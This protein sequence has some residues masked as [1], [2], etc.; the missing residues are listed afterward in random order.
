MEHVKD[1]SQD[2]RDKGRIR[3]ASAKKRA[4]SASAEVYRHYKRKTGVAAS[5]EERVHHVKRQHKSDNDNQELAP[6][7]LA[8]ELDLANDRNASEVFGKF[9]RQVWYLVRSLPEILHHSDQI[10]DLFNQYMLSLESKPHEMTPD[11]VMNSTTDSR[12][13]F[14]TNHA[15]ADILHLY[16]VLARD[17]RHEI[18]PYLHTKIVPRLVNDLLN[19]PPPESGKQ[20]IPLDVSVVEHVFRT[21]S[22]IFRYDGDALLSENTTGKDKEPCLESLRQ[23]YGSTLANRR[24]LV[25]R[26][27]AETYAPLIRKLSDRAQKRHVRRV[28]RALAGQPPHENNPVSQRLQAD[29]VDGIALL[30]FQLARGVPGKM[31]SKGQLVVKCVLDACASKLGPNSELV[32]GVT[33]TLLE[34]LCYHLDTKEAAKI[35]VSVIAKAKSVAK[36]DSGSIFERH[37]IELLEGMVNFRTGQLLKEEYTLVEQVIDLIVIV[38]DKENFRKLPTENKTAAISLLCS[39]WKAVP[40]NSAFSSRLREQLRFAIATHDETGD[41]PLVN[42]PLDIVMKDLVPALPVDIAMGSIGSVVLNAASDVSKSNPQLAIAMIYALSSTR[43]DADAM[44]TEQKD[45]DDGL[46]FLANAEYCVVSSDNKEKLLKLCMNSSDSIK[47]DS[48][49]IAAKTAC[50]VAMVP[51]NEEDNDVTGYEKQ[52]SKWL[53][54]L[55]KKLSNNGAM[56]DS[57][58]VSVGIIMDALAQFS[59]AAAESIDDKSRISDVLKKARTI[60]VENLQSHPDSLWTVK[61]SAALV[62]VLQKFDLLLTED[63]N[64]LFEMLTPNLHDKNHFHRLRTLEILSSFPKKPFVMDHADLDLT[65]DLD[66]EPSSGAPADSAESKGPMGV[67]NIIDTLIAIESTPVYFARERYITSLVS[68]VEVMGRSGKLPVLYAEAAASHM[69]GI[70]NIK[71]APIWTAAVKALVGLARGHESSVWPPAHARIA[72]LMTDFPYRDEREKMTEGT[73]VSL[74]DPLAHHMLC[75]QWETSGGNNASV[76]SRDIENANEEGRVSRHRSTDE[77]TV[78]E[79]L[80]KVFEEAPQLLVAHSRTMVPII[81]QFLHCQYFALHPED[82]DARELKLSEH[83]DDPR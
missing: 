40:N 36:D 29:A 55:L 20:P 82:P 60:A 67:C 25:R 24:Q 35:M 45:D 75:V 58:V 54:S 3:F 62:K 42:A 59:L 77:P 39:S 7:T 73:G 4:K 65:E 63:S 81:L 41:K 17:L 46:L 6:S 16:A 2:G 51:E 48:C 70:L 53:L 9:Y 12:P 74:C 23:Y 30:C 50:F 34:R 83:V 19:P 72:A 43:I 44:E 37:F 11:E 52:V 69:L 26:L 31:H 71:F 64:K 78:L 66:E 8:E 61:S 80:W 15:T 49:A 76:F 68:R 27:A 33:A 28:L 18:H 21:L 56:P 47:P 10:V 5:R 1:F 14:V 38:L 79:S 57:N 13:V 32:K 22:Y